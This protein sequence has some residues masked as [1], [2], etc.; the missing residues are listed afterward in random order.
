[1]SQDSAVS[2][3]TSAANTPDNRKTKKKAKRKSMEQKLDCLSNSLMSLR[4]IMMEKGFFETKGHDNGNSKSGK[5]GEGS[6]ISPESEVTVYRNA[7]EFVED[8]VDMEISFNVHKYRES[9][10][11]EEQIDTSDEILE[12]DFNTCFIADCANEAVRQRSNNEA[13]TSYDRP[14]EKDNQISRS[15]QIIRDAEA[16]RARMHKTGNF[17]VNLGEVSLDMRRAHHSALVD[18]N[19]LV[20]GAHLDRII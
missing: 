17:P 6:L 9:T 8:K 18:E 14:Q 7:V 10:S 15:E 1:M 4:D 13:S 11:S 2:N 20:V 12:V 19:Y 16:L 5:K 3:N